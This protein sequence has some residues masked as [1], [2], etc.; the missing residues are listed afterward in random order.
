MKKKTALWLRKLQHSTQELPTNNVASFTAKNY[1]IMP[2][3]WQ[4]P[5][6]LKALLEALVGINYSLSSREPIKTD[7]VGRLYESLREGKIEPRTWQTNPLQQRFGSSQLYNPFWD[8]TMEW[9]SKAIEERATKQESRNH[10][11]MQT[12]LFWERKAPWCI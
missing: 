9:K 5:D 4:I 1:K 3:S 2:I 7:K 11:S 8:V 12:L 6:D 10:R